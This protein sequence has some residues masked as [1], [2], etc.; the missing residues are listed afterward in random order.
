MLA[1]PRVSVYSN[2]KD[3]PLHF[4]HIP[5]RLQLELGPDALNRA[6]ARHGAVIVATA[7]RR[8]IAGQLALA[9]APASPSQVLADADTA[10]ADAAS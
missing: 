8:A 7:L 1:S 3:V 5:S 6:G 2:L 4:S 10:D 9:P